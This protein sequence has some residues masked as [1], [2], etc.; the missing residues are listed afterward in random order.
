MTSNVVYTYPEE[1]ITEKNSSRL[2]CGAHVKLFQTL[3][4]IDLN[5]FQ[6]ISIDY[7][8]AQR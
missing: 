7:S 3:P 4:A 1:S 6:L 2:L 5:R 8:P